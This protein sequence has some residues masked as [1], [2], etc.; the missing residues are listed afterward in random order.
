MQN[1]IDSHNLGN[2]LKYGYS[3]STKKLVVTNVGASL[4]RE[5]LVLGMSS[6]RGNSNQR[7]EFGEGYKLAVAVLLHLGAKVTI[8]NGAEVW[9]PELDH[10]P[11]FNTRVLYFSMAPA[12]TPND[13]LTF[14]VEGIPPEEWL[15]ARSRLL[16]LDKYPECIP[17]AKVSILTDARHTGKLY[18]KGI[19]VT[20]LSEPHAYGYD[21][22]KISLNRDR[23]APDPHAFKSLVAAALREA[24]VSGAITPQKILDILEANGG[25]ALAF[26][27]DFSMPSDF[28]RALCVA[29]DSKYGPDAIPVANQDEALRVADWNM[30]GVQINSHLL[31]LLRRVKSTVDKIAQ[32]G[33]HDIVRKYSLSELSEQEFDS[34]KWAWQLISPYES[35]DPSRFTVVDF[36][37]NKILG[38]YSGGDICIARRCLGERY[39]LIATIVHEVCHK[40]GGDGTPIHRSKVEDTLSK[41]IVD[42]F[43][44]IK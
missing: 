16:F 15:S 44:K 21:L 33:V 4:A 11:E 5:T 3:P 10:C 31:R 7:G 9:K 43:N 42:L 37:T 29:F 6:K 27:A 40:Y 41:I 14:I 8:L 30:V 1:G 35:I 28:E 23:Q 2:L 25:E 36:K 22:T 18:V 32:S 13:G 26:D 12:T 20:D 24:T 38:L 39:T 34:I 19:F 17:T